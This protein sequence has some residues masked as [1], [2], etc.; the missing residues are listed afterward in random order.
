MVELIAR[1][2]A[3]DRLSQ[4]I[5]DFFLTRRLFHLLANTQHLLSTRI[6]SDSFT[7][8]L[9]GI[10][11]KSTQAMADALTSGAP[12]PTTRLMGV[13]A[14]LLSD[15]SLQIPLTVRLLSID[16]LNAL[17]GVALLALKSVA[18]VT[19]I[20]ADGQ[21]H[22]DDLPCFR[23]LLPIQ[24]CQDHV[25]RACLNLAER[26]RRIF[27]QPTATRTARRRGVPHSP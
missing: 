27:Y 16:P 10:K 4:S 15:T 21:L 2:A 20:R 18:R 26:V 24:P 23:V 8:N 12:T 3:I 17:A 5:L 7:F 25:H 9:D 6:A 11:E 1:V 22:R 19:M 14:I 13:L